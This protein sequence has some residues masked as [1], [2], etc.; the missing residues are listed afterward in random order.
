MTRVVLI[1][2][3][4]SR[5]TVDAVVGGSRGCEGLSDIGRRQA[6]EL[7]A[8]VAR[9]GE[10]HG[11]TQLLA[12]T[13][14]RAVETAAALAPALGLEVVEDPGLCELDPG[15]GDALTWAEFQQ[16]FGSFDM[17]TDPYRPLAP[18]GES[19]ATFGL[20]VGETMARLARSGGLIVAVCHGGVIEQA[21]LQGM[22]LPVAIGP[23]VLFATVPNA[24]ITEWM[25]EAADGAA[26]RWRLLRFADAAHVSP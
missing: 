24:S 23:G 14:P 21:M 25:V 12:S 26:P 2:H 15:E 22:G 1:R 8:R 3:G 5:A 10:L 19:W 9:T 13:L 18:G 17:A 6:A 7:A 16:R 11:A 20:R 4:Q